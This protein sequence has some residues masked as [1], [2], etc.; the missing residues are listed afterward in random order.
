MGLRDELTQDPL[1]RGYA[2]MTA[3]QAADSLNAVNR[4]IPRTSISGNDLLA[5]TTVAELTGLTAASRDVYLAL[6]QMASLDITS[7]NVRTIL[8]T[9]FAAG[10]TTR[11]NLIALGNS[12]IAVSRAAE[13]GL[14][15]PTA[16]EIERA[17]AGA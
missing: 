15:A 16:G 4:A 13:L 17:R 1:G 3:Q 11:A 7:A 14:G 8:G 10:T 12:T 2:S 5:C 9:L 6:I